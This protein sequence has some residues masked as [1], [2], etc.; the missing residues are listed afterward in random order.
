MSLPWA[1]FVSFWSNWILI[2]ALIV[3][4]AA[5]YG[6]VVSGSIKEAAA[7]RDADIAAE[8]IASLNKETARLSADAESARAA[9]ADAN[10]RALEAQA[11]LAKFK[12][13]RELTREQMEHIAAKLLSF[14]NISFDSASEGDR[15]P[16]NLLG[17]IGTSLSSAGWKEI[18]WAGVGASIVRSGKPAAG[19][20]IDTGV[21]IQ[22]DESQRATL[23]DIAHTLAAALREEGIDAKAQFSSPSMSNANNT[24]IHVIV[25]RKP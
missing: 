9:I 3:G 8:H 14:K 12:A 7:K 11:E 24:A 2:A 4:V 15:E 25:G 16:L 10:A 13:P 19:L 21:S 20:A 6:V 18:A 22:F 5:T 23:E 1:E 17:A